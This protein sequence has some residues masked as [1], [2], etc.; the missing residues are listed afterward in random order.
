[1]VEQFNC[2]GCHQLDFER[3]D[4]EFK[5]G[6]LGKPV[7]T[8]DYPFELP[9][10]TQQ[11]IDDSKKADRRGLLHVQLYGLPQVDAKGNSPTTDENEEGDPFEVGGAGARF[12][13]WRDVLIDGKPWLVGAKNPLVPENRVTRSI[14]GRGG[15]LGS[16]DL[17]APSWPTS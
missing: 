14:A 4:V 7:A 8:T 1:M 11:E 15:D 3:W 2:T 13:L 5:S 12:I 9:H 17:S 6:E 10:F 16:L